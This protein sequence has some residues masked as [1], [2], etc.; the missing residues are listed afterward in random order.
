MKVKS[1]LRSGRL[2]ENL[3]LQGWLAALLG[4]LPT[5]AEGQAIEAWVQRYNGPGNGDDFVAPLSVD[6]NGN[7]YVTGSAYGGDPASGGS[8]NDWATIK[9]SSAGVPLWTN[10][11]NGPGRGY[12]FAAALA[13][14]AGGDVVVTGGSADLDGSIRCTTIKYSSAGEALWTN[15][16]AQPGGGPYA[17]AVD[18]SG[19]V[20]VTG[21]GSGG[22][23]VTIKYSRAGVQLWS[24]TYSFNP[25]AMQ[26]DGAGNVCVAG[27]AANSS[28]YITIKYSSTGALIWA[29]VYQARGMPFAMA[30]DASGN[31]V[32]AGRSQSANG[33]D[34]AT[35]KYSSAGVP[36][37]TNR[38]G[39]PGMDEDDAYAVAADA[40][41]NVLVAGSTYRA[42]TRGDFA[43]IKYSSVGVP[44]WTNWYN[45]PENLGDGARSLVLDAGGNVFVTG[46][47]ESGSS[48]FMQYATVAYSSAGA[49]LWAKRYNGPG[50]GHD[51]P[52]A[53]A[54]D[55]NGNVY[56]TGFSTG[57]GSGY[58]FATVKYVI[59]P[60]ITRQPL[61]RTNAVGTTASF[62]VEVAG[63]APFTYQWRK[64]E[65]DLV[66]DS[67]FSGVTTT[68]LLITN[69]Q[70]EDAVGYTVVV[71][72]AWGK[73]TSNLA[74]LTVEIPPNPGRFS[75][76]AYSSETGFRFIFRDG[77]VGRPY[78]I[79]RS[80]S[81]AE[82]GWTDWLSFNYS[83]PMALTDLGAPDALIRFY[84]AVSP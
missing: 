46:T 13:L 76:L 73:V 47:S 67:K 74:Q 1:R 48:E 79:Q 43:T 72:N 40:N 59:P 45:G 14:D 9:Y 25:R 83:G 32:V 84:R 80:P 22:G 7:V 4:L 68:N 34:Y 41:G 60:I 29:K 3:A 55:V 66:D 37:W 52:S 11:Y 6:T 77:T 50:N 16:Y 49:L 70:P 81:T 21:A 75:N 35:I 51:Q 19:D 24:R 42:G 54:L 58:D 18:S 12:D 31:V 10:Y 27:V 26:V 44:L 17:I 63:S 53:L 33:N 2:A 64:G 69:V 57:I 71:T 82:S 38:F 15:R 30:V 62:T 39:G 28:D 61:S 20:C 56:V 36:L 78:R 65:T 8:G 5:A 23:C